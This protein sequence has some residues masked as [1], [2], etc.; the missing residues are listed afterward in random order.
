MEVIL[1][2]DINKLGKAGDVVKVKDG[3][4]RNYLLPQKKA[5]IADP[6]NIKQLESQ[7]KMVEARAAK[8]KKEAEDI[9]AKIGGMELTIEKEAGEGDRLFGSVTNMDISAALGKKGIQ[10]DRHRILLESPIKN[11][12][13]YEIPIKVQSEV[14]AT[15][16]LWVVRKA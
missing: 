8:S 3:Y 7:K 1:T 4:G 13:T 14:T 15:L 11:I 9:A 10:V 12:G 2:E 6:S 16:K 5:L